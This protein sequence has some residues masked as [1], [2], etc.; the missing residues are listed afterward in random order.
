MIDV[1]FHH[2]LEDLERD[3]VG[4]ATGFAR[5]AP[6][7]VRR[8]ASE[9]QRSA[10]RHAKRR[11]GAHGAHYPNAITLERLTLLAYEYGPDASKKQGN[12]SFEDGSRNQP[13]HLDIAQSTDG[14]NPLLARRMQVV[15]RETWR[16]T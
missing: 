11:S 2:T 14:L 12:M 3:F 16:V 5:R 8:T 6:Q 7:A 1:Q 4:S 10:R 13:P 9:G 15:V